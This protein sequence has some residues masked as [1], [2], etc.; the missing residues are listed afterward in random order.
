MNYDY[1]AV[2]LAQ[3]LLLVALC[4]GTYDMILYTLS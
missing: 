3:G 1:I 4:L 2:R